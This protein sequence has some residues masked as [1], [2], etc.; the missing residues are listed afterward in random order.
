MPSDPTGFPEPLARL[1]DVLAKA[2]G[3]A[4]PTPRELAEVL[5][6]AGRMRAPADEEPQAP[7]AGGA[8]AQDGRPEDVPE[9]EEPPATSE[10]T[11]PT[12]DASA[13]RQS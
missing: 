7:V 9:P 1:A 2:S 11:A 3:G 4:R 8:S 6:L 5:W 10:E 13:V 12:A